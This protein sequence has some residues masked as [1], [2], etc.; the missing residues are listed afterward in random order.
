M[1]ISFKK[2][3]PVK[4]QTTRWGDL[5][6]AYKVIDDQIRSDLVNPIFNQFTEEATEEE[7][8]RLGAT[9]GIKILSLDGWTLTKEYLLRQIRTAVP[10]ITKK[11]SRRCYEYIGYIYNLKGIVYPMMTSSS[12]T[13]TSKLNTVYDPESQLAV[14][15]IIT[16]QEGDNLYYEEDVPDWTTDDGTDETDTNAIT[17]YRI[18]VYGDPKETGLLEAF[19]DTDTVINTDAVIIDN[20]GTIVTQLTRNITYSYYHKFLE[21]EG[22]WITTYTAQCL[23]NDVDQLHKD[24]ET[25][26]YEPWLKLE[27]DTVS[28]QITNT[29]Y[30]NYDFSVSGQIHNQFISGT[31]ADVGWIQFGIGSHW[32]S[33]SGTIPYSVSG[34]QNLSY[35]IPF[36]TSGIVDS[37]IPSGIAGWSYFSDPTPTSF[38]VHMIISENNK[39]TEFTEL[40]LL[41]NTSGCIFYSTFPIVQWHKSMNNNIRIN[42]NLV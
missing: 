15:V 4:M 28:G 11:T 27:E 38:D 3:L 14:E 1:A 16:D 2:L 37:Y 42:I 24:T 39:F 19:T 10:R 5:L 23:K 29:N 21:N 18:E 30:F 34:V 6:T 35:R 12:G 36:S 20:K 17:D 26:Y 32:S 25:I 33:I 9:L 13:L 7:L 22:E 8:I 31:M 41:T 40:A